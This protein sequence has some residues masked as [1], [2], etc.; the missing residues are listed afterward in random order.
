V[1][2]SIVAIDILME[3]DDAMIKRAQAVNSRLLKAFP[4]GY[5]LDE[6]HRPHLTTVQQFV[7]SEKLDALYETVGDVIKKANPAAWDLK[8]FKYYYLPT[9]ENGLA[10]IVVEPTAAWIEMQG[11][12]LD[13]IAPFAVETATND[14]F[15]TTPAEPD[16]VEGTTSRRS[17]LSTPGR[18]SCRTLRLELPPRNTWT[19]CSPSRSTRSRSRWRAH[20]CTNWAI[21]ERPANS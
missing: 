13:A 6:T 20:R 15:Y 3:P 1:L 19:P 4:K 16:I 10:G 14:A 5:S 11:K 21:T 9:G 7:R 17:F 12:I 8:A 18:I 2:S